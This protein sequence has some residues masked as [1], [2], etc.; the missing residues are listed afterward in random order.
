MV[1]AAP[2]AVAPSAP[3][4]PALVAPVAATSARRSGAAKPADSPEVPAPTGAEERGALTV[5]T[6]PS[7]A[8]VYLDDILLG[9]TPL[10]GREVTVGDRIL[11]LELRGYSPVSK[12]ASVQAGQEA[13]ITL[14]LDATAP[15]SGFVTLWGPRLDGAKIEVD[16][17]PVGILP[18]KLELAEGRHHFR[19][20]PT[21]GQAFSVE[22]DVH[23]DVQGVGVSVELAP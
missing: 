15:V 8:R 7:G 16:G 3:A 20:Q 4:A 9:L 1:S 6:E 14:R 23:F 17:W 11:R 5:R 10:I 21:W 22:K 12:V 18:V 2:A 13:T 19:V